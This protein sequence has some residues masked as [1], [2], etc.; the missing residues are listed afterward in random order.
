[1]A[2]TVNR[3]TYL[4][5]AQRHLWLAFGRGRSFY[6]NAEAAI[7]VDKAEGCWVIDVD[8]RRYLDATGAQAT[9]SAGY[10]NSKIISSLIGQLD[11]LQANP[12]TLPPH[13]KA[14]QLAERISEL[15]PAG[16]ERV[17]L[18][19][20][21]TDA[22]ETAIKIAR[23]YF[24]I[25]GEAARTNVIV[26]WRGYHG[27]SFE[28]TAASGNTARRRLTSPLPS[29]FIHVEP[30]YCYR[31]PFDLAYP[32]CSLRCAAEIRNIIAR[33]DASNIAAVLGE[34]TIGAG[35]VIPDPPGY[36]RRIRDFCDEFGLLLI[37]DEVITAFGR[38]GR[39]FESHRLWEEEGV[40]PD[41][42]TFG[43]GVSGGYYPIS[44]VL[45]GEHVASEFDAPGNAL[46][47]GYTYGGNP[48]GAA[49]ALAT[50]DFLTDEDILDGV[51]S[52]AAKIRDGLEQIRRSSSI[53]GDIRGRGLMY[54]LELVAD[55]NTRARFDDEGAV[56]AFLTAQ[57]LREGLLMVV[58][59]STINLIP[60]LTITSNEIDELVERLARV[61][62]ATEE[63]FVGGKT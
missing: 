1:M 6:D 48:I 52:K 45:V 43:K 51:A 25:R 56:Q 32:T 28:M 55:A 27:T 46:Q 4:E 14:I 53:V 47:H 11:E 50:I 39:W 5:K 31:C 7:V 34:P 54:G 63:R 3:D 62:A 40:L 30:P 13:T 57:G 10:R 59:G 35:G 21:G 22:N 24:R 60:P 18:C 26:R 42:I 38:T 15:A 41:L 61:I 49:V 58:G 37:F 33:H 29:G 44:G 8:G 9:S 19:A 20:N 2:T 16:F 12:S 23:Q 36:W 17:F